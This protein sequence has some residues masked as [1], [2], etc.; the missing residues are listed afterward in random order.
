MSNPL[1]SGPRLLAPMTVDALALGEPNL[2]DIVSDFS[3]VGVDYTQLRNTTNP[4]PSPSPFQVAGGSGVPQVG[5]ELHWTV[6]MGLRSGRATDDGVEFPLLP[7]RWLVVRSVTPSDAAAG[8]APTLSAW[9]L[10]SDTE[11]QASGQSTWPDSQSP[12]NYTFIGVANELTTEVDDAP[13]TVKR[14]YSMAPGAPAFAV[15]YQS[16]RNVLAFYDPMTDVPDSDISYSV[17]GFFNPTDWD[18][19]LGVSDTDPQGF[20]AQDQWQD[21][22]D[23]LKMQVGNGTP[24]A[25]SQAQ[26]AWQA[27]AEANGVDPSA[28]PEAQQDLPGQLLPFGAVQKL[29]WR[30]TSALYENDNIPPSSEIPVAMGNTPSEALG[31]WLGD[32][33]SA[34][35][36]RGYSIERLIQALMTDTVTTFMTNVVGFEFGVAN[37]TFGSSSGG[38]ETVVTLPTDDQTSQ[39]SVPLDAEQTA[40]LTNLNASEMQRNRLSD[41]L[42]SRRWEL[43]SAQWKLVRK[44]QDPVVQAAF[45]ELTTQVN[46]LTTDLQAAQTEV[47]SELTALENLLGTEYVASPQPMDQFQ[48]AND[49][50]ILLA[51]ILSDDKIV[52]R[53]LESHDLECRLSGQTLTGFT[54]TVDNTGPSSVTSTDLSQN[55]DLSF[56]GNANIPLEAQ[57]ILLE[58]FMLDPGLVAWLSTL[59]LSAAGGG[60]SLRDVE[61]AVANLQAAVKAAPSLDESLST[62]LMS[63]LSGFQ[64][65]APDPLANQDW[66]QPWTPVYIDWQGEWHPTSA[67]PSE[68]LND[69]Q[70]GEIDFEWQS[71]TVSSDSISYQ[72]RTLLNSDAPKVLATRIQ[73]LLQTPDLDIP[74]FVRQNLE[75]I[76]VL[77][78]TADIIVQSLSGF[79][80]ALIQ[81]A[82]SQAEGNQDSG[83][84]PENATVPNPPEGGQPPFLPIRSGHLALSKLWAVDAW[85]QVFKSNLPGG[86][87]VP[88]RSESMVTPGGEANQIYG[89]LPP[90]LTSGARINFNL[91]DA[92]A[93]PEMPSNS[94]DSTTSICGYVAAN[95][96]DGGLLVYNNIGI[97]QGELLPIVRDSGTGLRWEA[98]PGLDIPLGSSPSLE[99]KHLLAMVNGVIERAG[100]GIDALGELLDLVDG[101]SYFSDPNSAVNSNISILI[102]QPLAVVRASVELQLDGDPVYNQA[103][104]NT[105]KQVDDNYTNVSFPLRVGDVGLP[106]S[107]VVGYYIDDDYKAINATYGYSPITSE[108]RRTFF[109]DP[110][111]LATLTQQAIDRDDLIDGFA[112]GSVGGNSNTDNS[113]LGISINTEGADD[114]VVL[115][116]LI[117]VTP[118]D[119]TQ[120]MATG[121]PIAPNPSMLTVLMEPSAELP[122][123][124]GY[125]PLQSRRL[126]PGPINTALNNLQFTSRAG[127]LLVNPN[128]IK[129][130][131]PA[132]IK[133]TWDYVWRDSVTTWSESEISN[134]DAQAGLVPTPLELYWGWVRL[135]GAFSNDKNN[136]QT[137]NQAINQNASAPYMDFF[138]TKS[139]ISEPPQVP[140]LSYSLSPDAVLVD[141]TMPVQINVRNTTG[142][143]IQVGFDFTLTV[144]LPVGSSDIDLVEPGK[145]GNIASSVTDA[146]WTSS[147]QSTATEVTITATAIRPFTWVADGSFTLVMS[148]VAI[149]SVTSSAGAQ[150]KAKVSVGTSAGDIATLEL[151]KISSGLTISA[152]ANP[153]NVGG[154][155]S[156]DVFWTAT[157]GAKVEI[158]SNQGTQSTPLEGAGPVYSGK[159][160]V[161]PN[162]NV[163]QTLYTVEVQNAGDT[164]QASTLVVVNLQPPVVDSFTT[165]KT[166]GL[167][168]RQPIELKWRT[169]YAMSAVLMPGGNVP[170]QAS[171][172]YEFTP[173]DFV[174]GNEDSLTVTLVAATPSQPSGSSEPLVLQFLPA[175]IVY[176]SYATMNPDDGVSA[177]V[178]ANSHPPQFSNSGDVWTLNV[179]GPGGPLKRTIGADAPEVR[180]FGPAN[181]T[182]ASDDSLTLNYW[183]NDYKSGDILTIQPLRQTL[184]PD[185]DGKGSVDVTPTSTTEYTLEATLSGTQISN[186]IT[187][188]VTPAKQGAS[189]KKGDSAK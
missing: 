30:G 165:D 136:D 84:T 163:P 152:F 90:R 177:P 123:I 10:Q 117:S 106:T 137:D 1:W 64:G 162:Q 156:T 29:E 81:R 184:T 75:D 124:M 120:H 122:I 116:N 32:Q 55:L 40:T 170:V 150:I 189:A 49:P 68:A 104:E 147:T 149:N 173:A 77:L 144:R 83:E 51:S 108:L 131:L 161:Q 97:I 44:P 33:I 15:T 129:M 31:A 114:Y 27:W 134:Q 91:I 54:L 145:Q 99:N 127:P 103:Y 60:P 65:V 37:F 96:L 46:T 111:A 70:L 188:E 186:T 63:E 66:E 110:D 180:Y 109:K 128:T 73:V 141:Q 151:P 22:I 175:D 176:F 98:A 41:A 87:V 43:F 23:A 85:G 19:L 138:M 140:N 34:P 107:G 125:L 45:T 39:T 89:Q 57:S 25:L 174:T 53:S 72:G 38:S 102:G 115:N 36:V 71:T 179:T 12:V 86:F 157:D 14:L 80:D 183:V 88:I 187:V 93:E 159:F 26:A 167:D 8:T 16:A 169:S 171:R 61:K 133:G 6:P 78:S 158:S 21:Q 92:D 2:R 166:T 13:A 4:V 160:T 17:I 50:V 105:G 76:S 59:W 142:A 42:Q 168:F 9:L 121:A 48:N 47:A 11:D 178:V 24:S 164:K 94:S 67:E 5:V 139:L 172:G 126:P 143:D 62:Q 113:N 119:N 154:F 28:L 52:E 95:H 74:S 58:S 118:S 56:L 101:V 7:N 3:Q 148:Q 130:P 20:T 185:A 135:T 132:D 18:P 153:Q 181:S 69:W 100:Q 79:S 146:S 35:D 182:V 82:V 155:I 112:N